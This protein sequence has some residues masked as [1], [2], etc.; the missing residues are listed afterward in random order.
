MDTENF[1]LLAENF[2]C[3]KSG[4]A[5]FNTHKYAWRTKFFTLRVYIAFM[6]RPLSK[7]VGF[8]LFFKLYEE[9]AGENHKIT[10]IS[11]KLK[12]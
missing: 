2:F 4:Q 12:K 8:K 10:H 11:S 7:F 5:S 1:L 6:H 9:I 3:S